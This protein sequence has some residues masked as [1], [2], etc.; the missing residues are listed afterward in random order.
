M[1]T[2]GFEERETVETSIRTDF[3]QKIGWEK[4]IKIIELG[5]TII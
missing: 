1:I 2:H 5:E 3:N 4:T